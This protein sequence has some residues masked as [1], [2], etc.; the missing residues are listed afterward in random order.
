MRRGLGVGQGQ[1]LDGSLWIALMNTG[2]GVEVSVSD[3]HAE[4][5]IEKGVFLIGLDDC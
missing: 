5:C 3:L 1:K 4:A 2:G